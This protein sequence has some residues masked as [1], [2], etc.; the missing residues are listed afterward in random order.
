MKAAL[1]LVAIIGISSCQGFDNCIKA[2]KILAVIP[3][4]SHDRVSE[5]NINRFLNK[6][7]KL[8]DAQIGVRDQCANLFTHLSKRADDSLKQEMIRGLENLRSVE[9]EKR[10]LYAALDRSKSKESQAREIRIALGF[11]NWNYAAFVQAFARGVITFYQNNTASEVCT[12]RLQ[13]NKAQFNRIVPVYND[14]LQRTIENFNFCD[15]Q[16]SK[17]FNNVKDIY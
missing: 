10:N 11:A 3:H 4:S 7:N 6:Y 2:L 1:I 12:F 16:K 15:S 5:K 17:P 13:E 14:I 8:S 9:T